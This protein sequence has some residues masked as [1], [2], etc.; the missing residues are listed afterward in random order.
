VGQGVLRGPDP[1]LG[2]LT[3]W[4]TPDSFGAFPGKWPCPQTGTQALSGLKAWA[5]AAERSAENG[6]GDQTK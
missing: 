5:A 4:E 1:G 3:L 2:V 6:L